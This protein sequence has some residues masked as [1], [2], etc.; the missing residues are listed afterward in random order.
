[1]D[2][3]LDNKSRQ[4][5]IDEIKK[6]RG[7]VRNHRDSSKHELCWYQPELWSLLPEDKGAA[8]QVPA[9]PEFMKG[10]IAYRRSLDEQLPNAERT[11]EA[12]GCEKKS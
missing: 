12:F 6:L 11:N 4:E 9:W 3:D 5:L 2:S 10:C 7:A 8:L 1:M